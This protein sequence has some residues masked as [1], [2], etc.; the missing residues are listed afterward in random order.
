MNS[1]IFSISPNFLPKGV[2]SK[3]YCTNLSATTISP[4]SNLLSTLPAVPT[5]ITK[6]GLKVSIYI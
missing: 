3:S 1:P 4:I 2:T 5:L 6:L